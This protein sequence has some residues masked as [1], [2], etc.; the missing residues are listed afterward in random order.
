MLSKKRTV[1]QKKDMAW[2]TINFF[3]MHFFQFFLLDLPQFRDPLS[4]G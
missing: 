2:Y 1:N 3:G 4:K